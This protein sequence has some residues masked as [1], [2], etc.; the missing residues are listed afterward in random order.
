MVI[1]NIRIKWFG[2]QRFA[3][4]IWVDLNNAESVKD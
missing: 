4:M 2:G 1:A 3:S